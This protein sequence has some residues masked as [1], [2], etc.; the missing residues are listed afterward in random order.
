MR[1]GKKMGIQINQK[2]PKYM[3]LA[4]DYL[5]NKD[6]IVT[7]DLGKIYMFPN[8]WKRSLLENLNLR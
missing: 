7:I 3:N 5:E 6:L 4:N 8:N 1:L 2:K